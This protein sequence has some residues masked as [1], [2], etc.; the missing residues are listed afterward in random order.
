MGYPS[1]HVEGC[2]TETVVS[3]TVETR[4]TEVRVLTVSDLIEERRSGDH[5]YAMRG[6]VAARECSLL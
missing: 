3:C 1:Y 4:T 6:K 5:L 2:L